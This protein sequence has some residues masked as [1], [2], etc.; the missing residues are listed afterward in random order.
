M[1]PTTLPIDPTAADADAILREHLRQGLLRDALGRGD[2][3]GLAGWARP[4]ARAD[5]ERGLAAYVAN[6]GEHAERALGA[7]YPTVR[8]LLGDEA[9]GWLARRHWRVSPPTHGDLA[10]WGDGLPAALA[11]DAQLA[12]L[13]YLAE[14]ARLDDAVARAERAADAEVQPDTLLRLADTAPERLVLR[15]APGLRLLDGRHAAVSIWRAHH[16]PVR[17]DRPDPFAEAR[18]ALA[19]GQAETALVW[20]QGWAVRVAAPDGA[21]ARFIRGALLDACPLT[22][23]L[24]VAGEGFDFAA[25]LAPAVADGLVVRLDLI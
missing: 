1:N 21:A 13:P 14:V 25:W 9:F 2:A 5:V 15:A 17:R 23:A 12:E 11:D 24:A 4:L 18:A 16:D 6:A 19:A 22:D 7:R 20:R 3:R 8:A 10:D